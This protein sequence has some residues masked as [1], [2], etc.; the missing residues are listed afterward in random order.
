MKNTYYLGIDGGGSKCRARLETY[1][2]RLLST[3]YSVSA[4]P[5][6][7]VNHSIKAILKATNNALT[8]AG[9]SDINL[10]DTTVGLGL[11]GLA[12][13]N[14]RLELQRWKHPFRKIY[15][16]TDQHI[17]CLGAHNGKD[18]AVIIAGTGSS[19]CSSVGGKIIEYGG[20]GFPLGDKS[21]GAWLGLKAL[22]NSLL[23]ENSL[24]RQT[25]LTELLFQWF[26]VKE[27][28]AIIS[29]IAR[30]LPSDYA[31]LAPLVFEAAKQND[32]VAVEI[33]QDGAAYINQMAREIL[34]TSPPRFSILGGLGETMKHWL[35]EE[36]SSHLQDPLHNAEYGAILF[37]QNCSKQKHT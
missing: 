3:G 22:Q 35:H 13:P 11:A 7:G 27:N 31:K 32:E 20:H 12:L 6:E 36:V 33:I 16:T 21:S 18:G 28:S 10:K 25:M 34:K 9:V 29:K 30:G 26:E 19:G 5:L 15:M 24:G 37:A 8:L 1:D 17:A 14:L 2:G 4:N 23:S